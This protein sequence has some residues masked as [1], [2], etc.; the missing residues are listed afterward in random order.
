MDAGGEIDVRSGF[1]AIAPPSASHSLKGIA[2]DDPLSAKILA[3]RFGVSR[4]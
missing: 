2:P 4:L 1:G 3:L